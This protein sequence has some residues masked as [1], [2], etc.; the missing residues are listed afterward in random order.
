MAQRDKIIQWMNQYL[1]TDRFKDFSPIGLQI[2]GKPTVR[3]IAT[4]VSAS[5]ELFRQAAR[6]GAD[7]VVVHHGMFWERED[8]VLQ[9]HL[10]QRVRILLDND[11]TLA[12]YH[13]PLDAHPE[14]GNNILFANAM[15]FADIKPFGEYHGMFI[16]YQGKLKPIR[17]GDFVRKAAHFYEIQ[18]LKSSQPAKAAFAPD[19]PANLRTFLHGRPTITSAAIVSG[20][21]WDEMLQATHLGIDCFVTGS[22][23]EPAFNLA[24]E[25]KIHFVS[26]GH[27]A[28]ERVG[29]RELGKMVAKEFGVEAKFFDVENPL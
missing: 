4:G 11:M 24:R 1:Q 3:K 28:T 2:E 23:D 10:K 21:A 17:I 25:E 27:Y 13:L 20:G 9:G 6:W 12:G 26:F 16:G 19:S 15:G 8:R 22:A 14:I 18:I 5:M 7:M 29:I